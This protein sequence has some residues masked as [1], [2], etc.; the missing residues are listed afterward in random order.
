MESGRIL[1]ANWERG[2]NFEG[3][4]ADGKVSQKAY[5]FTQEGW[6]LGSEVLEILRACY[7]DGPIQ[8]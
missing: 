8:A 4:Y 1:Y 5:V 7:V 6:R 2:V 3:T